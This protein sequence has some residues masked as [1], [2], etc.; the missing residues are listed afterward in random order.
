MK[1]FTKGALITCLVLFITAVLFI[2]AGVST[3]G[4]GAFKTGFKT[5]HEKTWF[6]DWQGFHFSLPFNDDHWEG[7]GKEDYVKGEKKEFTYDQDQV[8]ELA[9]DASFAKLDIQES[10]NDQVEITIDG[11]KSKVSYNC[12]LTNG[13]V[14]IKAKHKLAGI[15]LGIEKA[16]TISILLP[17]DM[18]LS[19]LSINIAAG[20]VHLDLPSVQVEEVELDVAAGDLTVINLA[21]NKASIDVSAGQMIAE[22]IKMD[23][24]TINC[25]MGNIEIKN[26]QIAKELNAE[27]GMGNITITL[28]GQENE[29]NYE[30]SCGMGNLTVGKQEYSGLG[31]ETKIDNQAIIDVKLDCGMGNLEIYFN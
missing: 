20:D 25:G 30:L 2:I 10:N 26:L 29:F 13:K 5:L 8:K 15:N 12:K 3:S 1:K 16:L 23:N 11:V 14:L 9:V 4:P 19:D 28:N 18:S 21:G 7:W 24:C 6:Q 31:K 17:K 22:T 27:V